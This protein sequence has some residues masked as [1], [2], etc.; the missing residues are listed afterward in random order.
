MLQNNEISIVIPIFEC[1]E[2]LIELH[3]K[4]VETLN[5]LDLI[6]E[7]IFIDDGDPSDSWS[8]IC[9]LANKNKNVKEFF[10][11]LLAVKY[12]KFPKKRNNRDL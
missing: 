2:S 6:Y 1:K 3:D 12:G 10:R 9:N 4:L 7:I 11:L 5:T 8:L